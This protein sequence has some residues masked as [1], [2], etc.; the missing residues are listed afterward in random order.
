MA[1]PCQ[2]SSH[3]LESQAGVLGLQQSQL[4][5]M[6]WCEERCNKADQATYQQ[7]IAKVS[8]RL[9]AH[10]VLIKKADKFNAWLQREKRAPYALLSS[11][12]ELKPC[13]NIVMSYPPEERPRQ[14]VLLADQKHDFERAS[15][16]VA[17]AA[18]PVTIT[19]MHKHHISTL[20]ERQN[21]LKP[22][23]MENAEVSRS[24]STRSDCDAFDLPELDDN[25]DAGG[26]AYMSV[27]DADDEEQVT[28]ACPM[29][30]DN[31]PRVMKSFE[32]P[33]PQ[34]PPALSF[35]GECGP[36]CRLRTSSSL[37]CHQSLPTWRA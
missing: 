21:D 17:G 6:V 14:I 16:W 18:P 24:E 15:R 5:Y 22:W 34:A 7:S 31:S 25:A 12:R 35:D 32:M 10:M 37:S 11:W 8:R 27:A 13:I 30:M 29:F 36:L 9:G 23:T 1:A 2:S 26:D 33:S 4:R 3:E 19:I 28:N 20:I